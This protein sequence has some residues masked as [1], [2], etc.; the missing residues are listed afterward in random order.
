MAI[1]FD[2][3]FNKEI[4]REVDRANKKFARA[5]K[6]GFAKVPQ[7]I[8]VSEIKKLFGGKYAKRSEVRRYIKQYSQASTKNLSKIVELENGTRVNL[9]ALN[10]AKQQRQRLVRLYK[11]QLKES[12]QRETNAKGL[13]FMRDN[14][15]GLTNTINLLSRPVIASES[16]IRTINE[17]Y[18]RE[19]SSSKKESFEDAL[20]NTM[21]DQLDKIKL[22]SDSNKDAQMKKELREKIHRMDV[23]TLIKINR[24]EEDFADI[25]DRYKNK[26]EYVVEDLAPIEK[27]YKSLYK[28]IDNYV[29]VYGG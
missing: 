5:R 13:P 29:N 18:T 12:M 17:Y 14:I 24:E 1:R 2:K 26:D 22:S 10:I 28:N 8:K 23:D 6:M 19:F 20:F 27:A 21:D 16:Q 7:N 9:Q 4:R 11:K 3:A 15:E 25:L